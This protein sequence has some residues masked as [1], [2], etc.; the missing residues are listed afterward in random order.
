MTREEF[1]SVR[2]RF[3]KTQKEMAHL[4]GVSLKAVQ[5]F[6]QGWRKV[7]SHVERQLLFLC[8]LK[9]GMKKSL[10]PCWESCNCPMED[11][12]GCPAWEFRAGQFCWLVN[13][14]YCK[15]RVKKTWSQK[16]ESCKK[17]KIFQPFLEG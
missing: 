2:E 6:E 17:C 9:K 5:S 15:G 4:I 16:L 1:H 7:P 12:K 14:T 10:L 11:R 3:G 8:A 13:G